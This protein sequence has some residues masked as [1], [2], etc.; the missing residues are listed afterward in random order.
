LLWSDGSWKVFRQPSKTGKVFRLV[1]SDLDF[2]IFSL[3]Y[4]FNSYNKATMNEND[5]DILEIIG[6][7]IGCLFLTLLFFWGFI[8]ICVWGINQ[9]IK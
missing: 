2:C 5:K 9:I 6:S 7:G 4:L 3:D 1:F 8:A